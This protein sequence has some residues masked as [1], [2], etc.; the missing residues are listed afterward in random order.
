MINNENTTTTRRQGG[1][2]RAIIGAGD[3]PQPRSRPHTWLA[4][5][6]H[7]LSVPALDTRHQPSTDRLRE[8]RFHEMPDDNIPSQKRRY[9]YTAVFRYVVNNSNNFFKNSQNRKRTN[10]FSVSFI[11]TINICSFSFNKLYRLL[12]PH[13]ILQM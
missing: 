8:A 7:T 9:R 5:A 4:H 3:M 12:L 10:T 13:Q 1:S 2:G 6:W 11:I